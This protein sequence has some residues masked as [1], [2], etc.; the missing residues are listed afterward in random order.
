VTPP[1]VSHVS[2]GRLVDAGASTLKSATLAQIDQGPCADYTATVVA[3]RIRAE[4]AAQIKHGSF[5][6]EDEWRLVS[7]DLS[8][9]GKSI[10]HSETEC[11]PI[12]FRTEGNR[13]TPY[14]TLDFA[15]DR[16]TLVKEVIIGQASPLSED[17]VRLLARE[18]GLNIVVSRSEV[19]VRP[20]AR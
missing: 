6:D 1:F 7:I 14:D 10:L 16:A 8:C 13:I 2:Q 20:T 17:S 12:E 4:L 15:A 9:K 18:N 19:P 3:T 5:R 11:R